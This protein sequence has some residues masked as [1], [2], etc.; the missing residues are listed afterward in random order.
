M[1]VVDALGSG[2]KLSLVPPSIPTACPGSQPQMATLSAC[3]LMISFRKS[4]FHYNIILY[5]AL[6][7]FHTHTH[8]H[9]H[10]HSQPGTAVDVGQQVDRKR[11]SSELITCDRG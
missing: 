9:T 1:G 2:L 10:T 7:S 5:S 8:T 3:N 11:Q 4:K 6:T